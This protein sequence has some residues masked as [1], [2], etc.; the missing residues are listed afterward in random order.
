MRKALVPSLFVGTLFGVLMGL[1]YS[2][3]APAA[4]S[5]LV[6]LA[7][8]I[9]AALG[10]AAYSAWRQRRFNVWAARIC[11]PYEREGIVLHSYA[12]EGE[13]GNA[14]ALVGVLLLGGFAASFDAGGLLVLTGQRLL[15]VPH[16]SNRRG[17]RIDL[18]VTEIAGAGPGYGFSG[19]SIRI[20]MRNRST[21]YFKIDDH[22]KWMAALPGARVSGGRA[23]PP[24]S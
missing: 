1:G 15:F 21:L 2:L 9:S 3:E 11:A 24:A 16:G 14:L 17:T 7:G 5:I 18:P 22:A 8:G 19:R 10:F 4:T 12:V 23:T 6:G 20:G 13:S